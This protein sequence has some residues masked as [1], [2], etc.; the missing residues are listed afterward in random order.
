MKKK[1]Q[2]KLNLTIVEEVTEDMLKDVMAVHVE[3]ENEHYHSCQHLG[4]S[5]IQMVY[6]TFYMPIECCIQKSK[7]L[8][9]WLEDET[10]KKYMSDSKAAQAILH[11]IDIE[12]RGVEFDLLLSF[13][14]R[15]SFDFR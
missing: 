13:L 7:L 1:K 10:K 2:L 11:R 4:I 12:L 5:I 6:E 8:K 14:Y 9:T 3:I 15:E